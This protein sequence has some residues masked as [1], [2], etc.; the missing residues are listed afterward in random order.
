[1]LLPQLEEMNVYEQIHPTPDGGATSWAADKTIIEPLLCPTAPRPPDS[2]E[3]PKQSNYTG[4][5]GAGR[6]D[7]R[8]VLEQTACGDIYTDGVFF[9]QSR[10]RIAKIE[11]GA[12][13]TL[14]IGEQT[15]V[16][17]DWMSGATWVGKPTRI[18]TGATS[19]IRYPIN[20]D[21]NQ[22]GYYVGDQDAPIPPPDPPIL[23]NNWYFGSDHAGGAQFCFADGSVQFIQ[24][25]IDF[26]L[27]QDLSTR[28][29]DEVLQ[30]GFY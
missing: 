7:K 6:R 24:D 19:N 5:A 21:R 26:T 13:H 11:D 14:A 10:T 16:F 29:G 3:V 25:T 1:M 12:S 17:R 22:W 8:I 2:S 20:A 30:G 4:V 23:L 9:P 15:Y 18:C 27:Y 28:N